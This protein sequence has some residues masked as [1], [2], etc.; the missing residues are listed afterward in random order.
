MSEPDSRVQWRVRP[1]AAAD[2]AFLEELAPRLTIG[3]VPWLDAT[4][5]RETIRDFL[6]GHLE[7]TDGESAMLVAEAPD[8]APVGVVAVARGKHFTGVEHAYIGE[9]A[10]IAEVEGQGV[11]AALLSAAETWARE[12]GLRLVALDTSAANTRAREFYGRHGYAEE[13]VRLVKVLDMTRA[14]R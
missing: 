1:A 4:R 5:M 9:L 2:R 11:G 7:R 10:V 8:G 6:L 14:E 12:R 13:S 3:I